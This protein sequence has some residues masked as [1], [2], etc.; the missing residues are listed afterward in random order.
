MSIHDV[1]GGELQELGG[2][3]RCT[4][5]GHEQELGSVARSLD[6]GWPQ[7]CGYTMATV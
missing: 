2:L 3:L 1:I 4:Q 7:H 6:L 5:C